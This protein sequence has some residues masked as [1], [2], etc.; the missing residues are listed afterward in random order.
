[1]T[2]KLQDKTQIPE[3]IRQASSKIK[4]AQALKRNVEEA[5]KHIPELTEKIEDLLGIRHPE[6]MTQQQEEEMS[7]RILEKAKNISNDGKHYK[8][9]EKVL[10]RIAE[11]VAR[12]YTP[13]IV[14]FDVPYG[15]GDE[16]ILV[17]VAQGR[18]RDKEH[19]RRDNSLDI[20]VRGLDTKLVIDGS[21]A[22]VESLSRK[23]EPFTMTT[24]IGPVKSWP[25]WSREMTMED[26]SNFTS[27]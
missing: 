11:S 6:P 14:N 4:E 19:G 9:D 24:P 16:K 13:R 7:A 25:E 10:E 18:F 26:Y 17:S 22:I 27:F 8:I 20:T 1:M 2:E 15:E 12:K 23:T 3:L 5:Q 21:F